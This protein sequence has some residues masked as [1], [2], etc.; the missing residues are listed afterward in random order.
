MI[1]EFI[2]EPAPKPVSGAISK[3]NKPP[4]TNIS[5]HILKMN[6]NIDAFITTEHPLKTQK[7]L[8]KFQ[9]ILLT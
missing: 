4:P 5:T 1:I 6:E 3:T 8:L 7:L 2:V 9:K